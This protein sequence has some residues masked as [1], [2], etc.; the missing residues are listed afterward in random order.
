MTTC[1]VTGQLALAIES[2]FHLARMKDDPQAYQFASWE[3]V[4]AQASALMYWE[5]TLVPGICQTEEYAR[6]L[7]E[8]WRHT[9]EKVEELTAKRVKRRDILTR[10]EAPDVVIVIWERALY[11]LVGSPEVMVAQLGL[12]LDLADLPN[13]YVHIVPAGVR[14]G[15]GMAGPVWLA[16]SD[17]GEAVMME[18]ASESPVS[19]EASKVKLGRTILNSVRASAKDDAD[20]RA[21]ITEAMETWKARTGASPVTAAAPPGTASN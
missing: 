11:T 15:M 1:G 3:D 6:G 4:E 9:P 5:L 12:L 21:L 7:F 18:A 13:V 17:T 16:S 20:S 14:A 10:P 19:E 2:L 8:M